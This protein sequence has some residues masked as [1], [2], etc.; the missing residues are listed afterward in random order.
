MS[1]HTE[2]LCA[3]V[4]AA[5]ADQ[6]PLRIGAGNSKTFLGE[7][8]DP[9]EVLDMTTHS[10]IVNYRPQELTITAR[11]GTPLA[12]L[13]S[14]LAEQGQ[15]LAFDPPHYGATA[16][17][18]GT[19][20]AGLSGPARPYVGAARDFVLGCRIINGRGQA[21]RFGGEVMKNVAGYDLS[22]LM[23]GAYGTLGV[24]LDVSLKVLPLPRAQVTLIHETDAA[25]AIRQFNAWAG[26]PHPISAAY[27]DNG[28]SYLRLSGADAAISSARQT[29][30]GELLDNDTQLW[31]GIREQERDFFQGELPLWRLSIAPATPPLAIDSVS[32]DQ[33]AIGWGGAQ[34]W[35]VT[36]ADAEAVRRAAA[37]VG[38]HAQLYRGTATP[39]MHPLPTPLMTLHRNLKLSLDPA[40]V[41]NRG[42]LYPD[43]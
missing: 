26:K 12:K 31:R 38:G 34:R 8:G 9:G 14:V 39:R 28:R 27:W 11:A 43:L 15:M 1:D 13:Q 32:D 29:L 2:Q 16:T 40:G 30:G 19:I 21:L 7:A 10:G 25:T 23:A 3:T 22:R 18:G 24:L 5:Y 17:L 37:N 6:R 41:L 42:R 20:A 35:L 4:A 36:T 33:C